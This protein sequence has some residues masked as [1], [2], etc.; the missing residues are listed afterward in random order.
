MVANSVSQMLKCFISLIKY[1]SS[2]DKATGQKHYKG[3]WQGAYSWMYFPW[4]VA[5]QSTKDKAGY[6]SL[7][8]AVSLAIS[9]KCQRCVY[10]RRE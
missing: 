4:A 3:Q 2:P 10:Y 5:P 9:Q 1:K 7:E 8:L 6:I